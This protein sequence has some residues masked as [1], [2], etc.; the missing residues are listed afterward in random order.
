MTQKI[1][2]IRMMETPDV[3][4]IAVPAIRHVKKR[5]PDAEIHCLTFA[6]GEQI[7]RVAEPELTVFSLS[8]SQWPTDLLA[9]M[10]VFLGLA[11]IIIGQAYDEIINLDTVFMPCFLAR[12]LKDGGENV[13]GN[14]ISVSVAELIEQFKSQTLTPEYVQEPEAYLKSTWPGMSQWHSHWWLRGEPP[15]NGYPE[16]YLRRCCGFGAIEM[17]NRL[18]VTPANVNSTSQRIALSVTATHEEVN[19][20]A[21]DDVAS[22]LEAQSYEV[23]RG[24]DS[25][26]PVDKKLS[27]LATCTLLVSVPNGAQWYASAVGV[28]TLMISGPINPLMYMPDFATEMQEAPVEADILVKG[29]IEIA[30]GQN[31]A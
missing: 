22:A 9:A 10:E 15:A 1:L 21:G 14:M 2:I 19:Y 4:A 8:E 31:N 6:Q 17:D 5:L 24:L 23:W 13:E 29:I 25:D 16:F 27:M 28:P 20:A 18:A 7:I 26:M 11:D 3:A 30:Q 12:F